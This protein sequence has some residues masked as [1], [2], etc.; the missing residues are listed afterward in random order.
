MEQFVT[1]S[2]GVRM[3]YAEH[4]AA[5]GVPVVFLHGVTDSW[6][7]FERV[8]PLLPATIHAFA[9]SQ[10]GHGDSSRPA[11]GYRFADMSEDLLAFLDAMSLP[12]AVIVGHSMGASVAQRFVSDHP[13]RVSALVLMGSFSTY[14]ELTS[15]VASDIVPLTDPIAPA[16]AREWQLSTLARDI[17]PDYLD[18]VVSETLKVPARVWREAFD[19]FLATPDSTGELTKVSVPVLI[20]WGDRDTYARRTA[21]DRLLEVIPGVRF[22]TY[23]GHGHA[24][25]WE[26]PGRFANDLV[27]FVTTSSGGRREPLLVPVAH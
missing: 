19:G 12:T 24:L 6:H 4:G 27:A 22:I 16:F 2:T 3:E 17:P 23:E 13:D 9:V 8:L 5:D 15:F 14:D 25:H 18:T 10:R 20:V 11:S 26:D 1:L 7:S 21:Q